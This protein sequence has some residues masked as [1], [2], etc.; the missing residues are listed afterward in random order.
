MVA[1]DFDESFFL[2]VDLPATL[3]VPKS[4]IKHGLII[5]PVNIHTTT[6]VFLETP[7]GELRLQNLIHCV[8][9][10]EVIISCFEVTT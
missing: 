5:L 8:E 4:R 3:V 1:A 2:G 6:R 9:L 10:Y 7:C